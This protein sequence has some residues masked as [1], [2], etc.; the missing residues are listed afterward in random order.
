MLIEVA[1][2]PDRASAAAVAREE[3]AAFFARVA[4]PGCACVPVELRIEAGEVFC[5]ACGKKAGNTR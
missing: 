3:L 4:P 2:L 5:A 1:D